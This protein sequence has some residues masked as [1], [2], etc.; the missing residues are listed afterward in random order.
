MSARLPT[1]AAATAAVLVFAG[2][3]AGVAG[4]AETVA[5]PASACQAERLF[6]SGFDRTAVQGSG[7]SGGLVSAD[8][9]RVVS[10]AGLGARSYL[11]HLPPSYDPTQPMPL[12]VALHGAAGSPALADPV[13]RAL[14]LHWS[15][16][17][18]AGGFMLLVPVASGSSG[19][20]SPGR[21]G[22]WLAAALD[23]V[24]AAYAVDT[25][26]RLLWGFSAG[27]HWGYALALGNPELFAGFGAH[28]G[29]LQAYACD[30]SGAPECA[31]LLQ[32]VQPQLPI[33]IRVGNGDPLRTHAVA[34]R[35]RLLSAGW[36]SPGSLDYA[37]FSGG[38]T[39]A[40]P[41][42]AE[43]WS[44]LCRAAVLP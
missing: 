3:T 15:P 37:Q 21:D 24:A 18:D 42:L 17:A 11:L 13:A 43:A 27:A 36:S 19:G 2:G 32:Q 4:A 12:L 6:S 28:A 20:W 26:R 29:A 41:H 30:S 9:D 8:L 7:G 33:A 16:V 34:D 35:S 25:S 1:L 10:V 44:H 5:L 31:E 23:D 14:R 22:A 38:H 39:Y 40:E